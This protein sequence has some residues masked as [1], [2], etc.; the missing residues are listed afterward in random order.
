M[1]FPLVSD[2]AKT[3]NKTARPSPRNGNV[4][5]VGAH[6]GNTG[7]KKGRS[8]RKPE[9]FKDFLSR[10]R[11]NPKLHLA[12]ERAAEDETCAGFKSALKVLTDYDDD[13]PAEKKQISGALE[14]TVRVA[15][16]GR[17]VTAS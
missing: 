15:K 6:P 16:E 9:A 3:A 17:R 11:Q 7:G 14:V 10:L 12:L 4:L 13:K 8:G 2:A 1:I 5:P